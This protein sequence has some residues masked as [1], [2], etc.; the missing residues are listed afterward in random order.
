MTTPQA[1]A[2]ADHARPKTF[3]VIGYYYDTEQVFA[4][5][6]IA[7]DAKAA[8]DKTAAG[9]EVWS[10]VIVG[11][12]EGDHQVTTYDDDAGLVSSTDEILSVTA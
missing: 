5:H 3:T 9:D 8:M 10:L 1:S 6:V 11:A 2:S 4:D 12:I 7:P